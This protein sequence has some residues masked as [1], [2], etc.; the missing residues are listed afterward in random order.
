MG[1]IIP[2]LQAGALVNKNVLPSLHVTVVS[3]VKVYPA[4]HFRD[5]SLP[6]GR[7]NCV[8]VIISVQLSGS[9]PQDSGVC[10]SS[11]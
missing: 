7:G 10:I 4:L 5:T 9:P 2:R 3:P 1:I 11:Q 6:G 8:S